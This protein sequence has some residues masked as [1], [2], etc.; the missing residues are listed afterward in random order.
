MCKLVLVAFVACLIVYP[1]ET[2]GLVH[3]GWSRA[4]EMATQ[5]GYHVA[6]QLVPPNGLVIENDR[7][8][9]RELQ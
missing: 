5:L 6:D 4:L 9:H 3:E 7:L 1:V 8:Q 2:V